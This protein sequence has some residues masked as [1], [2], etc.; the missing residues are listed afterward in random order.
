MVLKHTISLPWRN[1]LKWFIPGHLSWYKHCNTSALL[2]CPSVDLSGNLTTTRNASNSRTAH[3]FHNYKDSPLLVFAR[4]VC[5][6]IK[7]SFR[8]INGS[9]SVF[10]SEETSHDTPLLTQHCRST[11]HIRESRT[12]QNTTCQSFGLGTMLTWWTWKGWGGRGAAPPTR[13]PSPCTG[14]ISP[15]SHT[16]PV[17]R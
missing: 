11:Q 10:S 16:D 5:L 17:S 7:K 9:E 6:L 3:I 15:P 2:S 4:F 13:A 1:M 12:E 8:V 14:R